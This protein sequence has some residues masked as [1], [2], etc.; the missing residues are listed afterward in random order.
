MDKKLLLS[1]IAAI[2]TT[3]LETNGSP[4]SMLYIFCDMNM[5][6]YSTIR[7]ILLD[8]KLIAIK[9]HYVTLTDKGKDT[10]QQL[11]SVIERKA[12]TTQGENEHVVISADRPVE[13]GTLDGNTIKVRS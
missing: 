5:D 11:N 4:E 3:L 10:A 6:H 7:D 1:R 12:P 13:C 9:G 2:L 8:S